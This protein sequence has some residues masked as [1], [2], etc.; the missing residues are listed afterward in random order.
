MAYLTCF[1]SQMAPSPTW[2]NADEIKYWLIDKM[3]KI[4]EYL[5]KVKW[6]ELYILSFQYKYQWKHMILHWHG[7]RKIGQWWLKYIDSHYDGRKNDSHGQRL[8]YV[9]RLGWNRWFVCSRRICKFKLW[10]TWQC[11]YCRSAHIIT[12]HRGERRVLLSSLP[13]RNSRQLD[14]LTTSQIKHSPCGCF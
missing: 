1:T 4:F 2:T 8:L 3:K 5:K 11:L 9:T 6:M 13:I 7:L 10:Y 12:W 14:M